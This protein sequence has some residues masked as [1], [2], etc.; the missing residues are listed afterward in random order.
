MEKRNHKLPIFKLVID[1]TDDTG[2]SF[3]SLVDEPAIER[4]WMAFSDVKQTKFK[5]ENAQK[6]MVSGPLMVADLPIFRTDAKIGDYYVMFDANTIEQ[7]ALKFFRKG[8]QGNVNMQHE[9]KIEGVYMFESWI[10]DSKNGKGVPNGFDPL[11]DGSWFGTFKVDNKEVWDTFIK[12]GIFTGFSVEGM[13][14]YERIPD[15]KESE[16]TKAINE[17][18]N[19]CSQLCDLALTSSKESTK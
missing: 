14:D 5:A 2:V 12:D 8:F 16:L 18:Q 13:F 9:K 17:I 11:P 6:Q 19:M 3:V 15:M 7:I 1:P 10:T 4:A